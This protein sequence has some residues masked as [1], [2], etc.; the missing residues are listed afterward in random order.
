MGSGGDLSNSMKNFLGHA[1][2]YFFSASVVG[3]S[4]TGTLLGLLCNSCILEY[5]IRIADFN[6]IFLF[7]WILLFLKKKW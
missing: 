1:S 4:A 3:Y 5:A 6:Y 2:T 7:I